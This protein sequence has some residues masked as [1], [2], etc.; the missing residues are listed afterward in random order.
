MY[1]LELFQLNRYDSFKFHSIIVQIFEVTKFFFFL[2]KPPPPEFSTFPLHT[3]LPT[4]PR[5]KPRRSRARRGWQG[6]QDRGA[7]RC[8]APAHP[9]DRRRRCRA[10]P[11]DRRPAPPRA[12]S[13]TVAP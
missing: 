9:T 8:A 1:S 4:G 6:R 10:R 3:P 13:A 2:K 5:G 11:K 7:A 12:R